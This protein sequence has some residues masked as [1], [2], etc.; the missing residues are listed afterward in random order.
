V[1]I[2]LIDQD[3]PLAN[4]EL[5]FAAKWESRFPKEIFVSLEERR[6]FHIKDDYPPHLREHVESIYLEKGFYAN[7]PIT[8]GGLQGMREME[9]A[10]F[11]IYICTAPLSQ[12]ENCVLEKYTWM[13]KHF[14][15]DFTRRIIVTKDKTLIKGDFLIDDAPNVEGIKSPE[16]KHILFDSPYNRH[17]TDRPRIKWDTWRDILPVSA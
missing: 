16:W 13:E 15:K 6:T 11:S 5:G 14:G 10:G 4:F 7:L 8:N 1:T 9:N 2:V 3:G 12:Y 17:V